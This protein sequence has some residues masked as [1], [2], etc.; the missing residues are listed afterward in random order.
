MGCLVKFPKYYAGEAL[1]SSPALGLEQ[2]LWTTPV[3]LLTLCKSNYEVHFQLIDG[4]AFQVA[5]VE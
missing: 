5:V 4:S 3:N 2:L 1:K